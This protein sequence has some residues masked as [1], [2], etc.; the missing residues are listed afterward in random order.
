VGNG[1]I[2][3]TPPSVE[4]D[5]PAAITA[6]RG[7]P[8]S[9]RIDLQRGE[10]TTDGALTPLCRLSFERTGTVTV[11]A[12]AVSVAAGICAV[13]YVNAESERGPDALK[14]LGIHVEQLDAAALNF[15]RS[16][17]VQH[18]CGRVRAYER[19]QN[20]PARTSGCSITLRKAARSSCSTS[21]IAWDKFKYAPYPR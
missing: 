1:S 10:I 6:F 4:N 18:H 19:A 9:P 8:N 17:E 15:G 20:F 14:M 2:G 3:R 13:G 12:F 7:M 5:P 11:Q 21:G 16:V